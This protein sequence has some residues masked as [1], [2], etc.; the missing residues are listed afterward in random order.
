M[1]SLSLKIE[2]RL[3]T[4]K[5][6]IKKNCRFGDLK[7]RFFFFVFVIFVSVSL[8]NPKISNPRKS[9]LSKLSIL[10]YSQFHNQTFN[11]E[12]E[13]MINR[14]NFNLSNVWIRKCFLC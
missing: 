1:K 3:K 8:K 13:N 14:I 2:N 5:N 10:D 9:D 11:F 4:A 7:I 6:V 12:I